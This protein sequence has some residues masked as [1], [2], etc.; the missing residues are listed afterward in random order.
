M[1]DPDWIGIEPGA[2][3][4]HS[5]CTGGLPEESNR[6]QTVMGDR[7]MHYSGQSGLVSRVISSRWVVAVSP[8]VVYGP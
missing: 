8:P 7:R 4:H 1:N 2:S 3:E 5:K 6:K